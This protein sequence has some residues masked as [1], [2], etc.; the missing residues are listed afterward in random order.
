MMFR[1]ARAHEALAILLLGLALALATES[2][3]QGPRPSEVKPPAGEFV[4]HDLVTDNPAACRAF[5]GALFGWTFEEGEG[6]DPGYTIIRHEGRLVGGMVL[7]Q[8]RG[9]ET[10]V[11]QWLSYVAVAD[12]D[13][14]AAEF[15]RSGGRI[16][17]GPLN[18]KK[19]LRVAVVADAQ[20]APLGLAS[21]G[22]LVEDETVPA[23]HRWLWMEYVALDPDA[24]LK[25]LGDAVGFGHETHEARE[26]FTYYLLTTTRPRA[27]LF[28]S[29]WERKTSAWL[30]Y[31]RVADPAATAAR[32]VKFGGT[33]ALAPR[34]EV[35]NG[36]LAIVLD[37]SGAPLA[38]QKFPFESGATP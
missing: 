32:V 8:R 20:G 15:Q 36:S 14:A 23:V 1:R 2:I 17:R 34:P 3:A 30:P 10:P 5:Y 22:P 27:G 26:D 13:R 35:R 28:R 4:W 9:D 37:P 11:A 38:L 16:I 33:V 25:F 12:V 24:A 31:V 6:V 7:L 18:A 21:R 19:N 29:P